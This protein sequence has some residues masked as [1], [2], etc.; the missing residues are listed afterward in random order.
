M[1]ST[2]LEGDVLR[3]ARL[4]AVVF[5]VLLMP[6]PA[7]IVLG[8]DPNPFFTA[9]VRPSDLPLAVLIALCVPGAI[10]RLRRW[11][12]AEPLGVALIAL[13]AVAAAA[14]PSIQGL[15][16]VGRL[17]GTLAITA[18]I[19]DLRRVDERRFLLVVVALT[20]IA[21]TAVAI[22]QLWRGDILAT[23]PVDPLI[24]PFT[25]ANGTLPFAYVLS[26]LALVCGAIL[27]AQTIRDTTRWR[28]AWSAAAAIALVPVGLTF[29]RAAAAGLA[30]GAGLLVPGAIRGRRGHALALAA[31]LAGAV[32]PA[33]V[34]RDGWLARNSDSPVG[35]SAT[36]R[37]ATVTQALPLIAAE[38]IVGVGPGRTMVALR[39]RADRVPG[40]VT[41]LNPPHDVPIAIAVEAGVP[42]GGTALALAALLGLRARRRGT[43]A[44][45]AFAVLVPFLVFDNWPYTTGAG[46]I[47]LGL[48]A[49]AADDG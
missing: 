21:Q 1:T 42:A 44:L 45:V 12:T 15:L 48:W 4:W 20:A 40:S 18:A 28:F 23:G 30:L 19:G 29:S 6:S 41:E 33:V 24:G 34:T 22:V 17:A 7:G 2:T 43:L 11:G 16:I 25:R 39:D 47:V 26:G 49:A 8:A 14:H 27:A 35:G 9:A 3:R 46:L 5:T 37:L 10:D 13:V 38:P 32:L 36:N 31:I